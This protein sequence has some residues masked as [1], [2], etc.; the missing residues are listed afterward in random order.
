[1]GQYPQDS[2]I[3]R[4]CSIRWGCTQFQLSN[5]WFRLS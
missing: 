4:Y 3:E 2:H 1:M 5:A